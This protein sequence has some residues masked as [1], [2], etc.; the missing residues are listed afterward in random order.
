MPNNRGS[1][2]ERRYTRPMMNVVRVVLLCVIGVLLVEVVINIASG[3]TGI[4]EKAV[5]A[6]A[7]VAL[8]LAA[9]RAW[10]LGMPKP[11]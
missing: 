10:R 9:A 1:R 2:S 7:G 5:I 8:V 3:T 6:V 4:L 11:R